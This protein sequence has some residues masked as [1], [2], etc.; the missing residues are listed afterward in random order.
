[1][2]IDTRC[3]QLASKPVASAGTA[4]QQRTVHT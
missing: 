2:R 3:H 4:H 1:M